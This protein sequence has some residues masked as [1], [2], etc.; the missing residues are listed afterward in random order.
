MSH[1][2]SEKRLQGWRSETWLPGF[3]VGSF[4]LTPPSLKKSVR[5]VR[6]VQIVLGLTNV[7]SSAFPFISSFIFT[8]RVFSAISLKKYSG[9]FCNGLGFFYGLRVPT[10]NE[11]PAQKH[12]QNG[13]CLRARPFPQPMAAAPGD[14]DLSRPSGGWPVTDGGAFLRPRPRPPSRRV[15]WDM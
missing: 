3:Q 14:A 1:I 5:N 8:L 11:V 10:S 4:L 9:Y 15:Y 6:M 2:F 7:I 12:L 13:G